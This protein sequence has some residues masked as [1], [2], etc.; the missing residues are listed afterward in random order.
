[1]AV[2]RELGVWRVGFSHDVE[3]S[4]GPS[5]AKEE[6]FFCVG[7]FGKVGDGGRFS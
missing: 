2:G 1:M 6:L 7:L 4:E 5:Y 3:D